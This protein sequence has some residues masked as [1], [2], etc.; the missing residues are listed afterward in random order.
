MF[1]STPL[2]TDPEYPSFMIVVDPSVQD[3]NEYFIN[4]VK[5]V[6]IKINIHKDKNNML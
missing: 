1:V 2:L 3:S 4:G 5:D 6:I